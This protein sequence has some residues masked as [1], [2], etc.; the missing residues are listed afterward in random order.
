MNPACVV[1]TKGLF[2]IKREE[3]TRPFKR[4]SE[5]AMKRRK[6]LRVGIPRE[7]RADGMPVNDF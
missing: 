7:Y 3:I 5:E 2:R 6:S 4:S 1:V